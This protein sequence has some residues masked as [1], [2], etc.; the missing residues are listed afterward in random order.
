MS[1]QTLT[2][3]IT[4]ARL[5]RRESAAEVYQAALLRS[6]L[7][8]GD[9]VAVAAAMET[10]GRTPDNLSGDAELV[11]RIV[12]WGGLA[13]QVENLQEEAR[14]KRAALTDAQG[15]YEHALAALKS[16]WEPRLAALEHA[17]V[18]TRARAAEAAQARTELVTLQNRWEKIV[19]GD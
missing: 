14:H 12:Q 1:D 2:Q 13:G 16:E 18:V 8:P 3:Q 6:S 7:D 15:E 11:Q 17:Y 9:E 10:L 4:A 19:S 5:K